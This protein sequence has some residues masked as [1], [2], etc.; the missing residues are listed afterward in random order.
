LRTRRSGRAL[1]AGR[2]NKALIALHA[3]GAG[4]SVVALDTLRA[5]W[6][7]GSGHG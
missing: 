2:S 4:G 3:L 7:S 5:C 1:R 6:T